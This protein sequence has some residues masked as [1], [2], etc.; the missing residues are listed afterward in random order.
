[1]ED[2]TGLTNAEAAA[3]NVETTTVSPSPPAADG[4]SKEEA[5]AAKKAALDQGRE[6]IRENLTKRTLELADFHEDLVFDARAA[7][8]L[9][10]TDSQKTKVGILSLI[11]QLRAAYP[12]EG[13]STLA[14]PSLPHVESKAESILCVRL[15]LLA[16]LLHDNDANVLKHMDQETITAIASAVTH[17]LP[18]LWDK[19]QPSRWFSSTLLVASAVLGLEEDTTE[20]KA[21][22]KEDPSASEEAEPSATK[23]SYLGWETNALQSQSLEWLKKVADSPLE[24]DSLL[25]LYRLVMLTTRRPVCAEKFVK[26]GGIPA[27][28]KPFLTDSP[29]DVAGCQV[30]VILILRHV[31]EDKENLQL[32]MNQEVKSW[33]NSAANPRSKID[34][35]TVIR[36]LQQ[37]SL[38][39]PNAFLKASAAEMEMFDY[40]SITGS[41]LVRAIQSSTEGDI[42]SKEGSI[43][44]PAPA[45]DVGDE[46]MEM[47]ASPTKVTFSTAPQELD[48]H[49][50]DATKPAAATSET[51]DTVMQF[52]LTELLRVS[53]E[54]EAAAALKKATSSTETNPTSSEPDQGSKVEGNATEAPKS[55][56]AASMT[57]EEKEKE[58]SSGDGD[59]AYLYTS[60]IM[61]CLTELLS[62]YSCCKSSFTSFTRKRLFGNVKDFSAATPVKP[63]GSGVLGFF[64]AEL[65]PMGF[66][67]SY[68]QAELRK[69]MA[70]SNWAMSVIVALSAD[71]T[72]HT[73]IKEVAPELANVRRF[74][75]DGIAKAIKDASTASEPIEIR[76]GRL[77]AL[78]DLCYRLLT[79]RPNGGSGSA[80]QVE[81]LTLHMAKTMLEKNFVT[82][83]TGALADVDLNLPSV[84]TLL[85]G[86]LRPLEHLTKV[87]I[88]MGKAERVADKAKAA[89]S[90]RGAHHP[91]DFSDEDDESTDYG[92]MDDEEELDED[93]NI[94]G[95][96]REATP[97]FYRNSSLGMHTGEMESIH[98]PDDSDDD[99]DEDEDDVEMEEYSSGSDRS[100]AR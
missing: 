80:K 10:S 27:M 92:S 59:G 72:I 57:A 90:S 17:L 64:L 19:S 18:G 68:E 84:K 54:S 69:R 13:A 29:K 76:Y 61:Q 74:V 55:G 62:S 97:D 12:R 31:I 38:R 67:Q 48:S 65:V 39:N 100:D 83:L 91:L 15:R 44:H 2:A 41:G 63:R 7:F 43:K 42:N 73:D 75:L 25:A 26:D 53:K 52:L 6:K 36:S 28:F 9:V 46:T 96:G 37:T 34:T 33:L 88:K 98:D 89:L 78:A 58:K 24:R 20:V 35:S 22:S 79:A 30:Y 86:I 56:E 93:G 1:M 3:E 23:T 4:K 16:L 50:A 77:Y 81:D 21:K 5:D 47:P 60:F 71:V 45:A 14:V 82:I 51:L 95:T 49:M 40:N 66:L 99:M 32:T 87:A 94:A 11:E 70:Q 85:D 8:A